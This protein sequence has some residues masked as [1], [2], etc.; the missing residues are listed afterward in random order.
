M[1]ET[2][3]SGEAED[4]EEKEKERSLMQNLWYMLWSMAEAEEKGGEELDRIKPVWK[5]P[6]DISKDLP[7]YSAS[8]WEEHWT[9]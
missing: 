3:S 7:E 5:K 4:K 6:G 2:V 1:N 8:N 9:A